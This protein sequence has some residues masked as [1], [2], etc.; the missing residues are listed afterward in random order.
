MF[1]LITIISV[2][3]QSA[4][5]IPQL[6]RTL[7]Q[8]THIIVVDNAS[9]DNS[10][11]TIAQLL[12]HACIIR[13]ESNSGFGAANNQA[14]ALVKTPYALLLNPD[15]EI[16]AAAL[17][18]LFDTAERYPSAAIVAPQGWSAPGVP[19][20]SYRQAFFEQRPKQPYRL[21]DGVCSAKWLHGCCL[22]VRSAALQHLAGFDEG[23]FLYYEDDDLCL[24]ALQAG[25]DCLLQPQA[26]V[27][28]IGGASSTPSW[29][30]TLRKHFYFFQS[31]Y[32]ILGKHV[33][34]RAAHSYRLRT[35]LI[36]PFATLVYTALFQRRHALKWLA[37]GSSAWS[38][39]W[40]SI[41]SGV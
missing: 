1:D 26:A 37:W 22:F 36:S 33:G 25:Y 28:H 2:T 27:L 24:R 8:F 15:C 31:R 39:L 7:A 11:Q 3:H 35:A 40:K 13:N 20:P 4:G 38:S 16:S 41:S 23:F 9:R 21:A 5:I 29:R 18:C 12:P 19:Q 17:Q 10:A 32:R 34:K 14:L 30:I 6:A